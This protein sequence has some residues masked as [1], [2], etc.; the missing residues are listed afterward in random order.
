[1]RMFRYSL[2]N[3]ELYPDEN[4]D[5]TVFVENWNVTGFRGGERLAG[6]NFHLEPAEMR[7]LERI[8]ELTRLTGIEVDPLPALAYPGRAR[9]LMLSKTLGW[10]FEEFVYNVISKEFKVERQV[11]RLESLHNFTGERFHNRPDFVVNGKVALEAKVSSPNYRQLLEYSK[12][13][14][15]GALIMP[16][17]GGFAVPPGWRSF[18]NFVIDQ[19]PL[20][21]WLREILLV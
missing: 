5:V 19:S 17:S 18:T 20:L 12:S 8:R 13:Y 15:F 9:G 1:M 16:F 10:L 21:K 14:R 7:I 11:K 4:G 2:R 3:G 6:L